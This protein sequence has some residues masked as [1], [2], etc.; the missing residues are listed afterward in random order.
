MTGHTIGTRA[1]WA[2][3]REELLAREKEQTRLTRRGRPPPP[4]A[5]LV[6]RDPRAS[7]VKDV[8]YLP[9]PAPLPLCCSDPSSFFRGSK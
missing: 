7:N 4:S 5:S 8:R 2:A 1:Q 9:R 3:A 6:R